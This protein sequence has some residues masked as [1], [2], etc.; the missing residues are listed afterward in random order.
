[1]A[2]TRRHDM[3]LCVDDESLLALDEDLRFDMD[4]AIE[5]ARENDLPN[6]LDLLERLREELGTLIRSVYELEKGVHDAMTFDYRAMADKIT[7]QGELT[8]DQRD[9]LLH[10]MREGY[11][12]GAAQAV[13]CLS[14]LLDSSV[15]FDPPTTTLTTGD[16]Q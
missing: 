9:T 5:H 7:V 15:N 8:D 10:A 2:E 13:E 12:G 11:M 4:E 14:G 6:T 1:M 16:P 3:S